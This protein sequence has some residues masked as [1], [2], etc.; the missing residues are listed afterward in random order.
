MALTRDQIRNWLRLAIASRP[1]QS[2]SSLARRAGI[3]STTITLRGCLPTGRSPADVARFHIA[4]RLTAL[5]A[6]V[7]L[8]FNSL[9][10]PKIARYHAAARRFEMARYVRRVTALMTAFSAVPVAALLASPEQ[11]LALFGDGFRAAAD[12]V[13]IM[14]VGQCF[15]IVVG[16]VGLMLAMTGG[17]RSM[18]NAAAAVS[19]AAVLALV[20]IVPDG[21]ITGAAAVHAAA[22]AGTNVLMAFLVYRS[23]GIVALPAL[24]QPRLSES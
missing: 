12:I 4:L 9:L 15:N 16:P 21:G 17:E 7:L 22:L 18:R 3:A 2:A 20:L 8:S 19:A 6:I 5:V 1:G 14:T 13:R 23:L 24:P 10:A 11:I